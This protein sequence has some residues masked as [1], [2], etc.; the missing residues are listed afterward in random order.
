M[1]KTTFSIKKMD[2]PAE[3]QLIRMQ[4]GEFNQ[5]SFLKFDIPTRKLDVYHT[6]DHN[7]IF[8]ALTNLQLETSLAGSSPVDEAPL[9]RGVAPLPHDDGEGAERKLLIQVLVINFFFFL[10]ESLMGVIADSMGLVADSLDMLADSF[11]YGL[12]LFAVGGTAIRKKNIAK[13]SGYFQ[14]IL[15]VLGIVEVTRRFLGFGKVPSFQTMIG[16]STLALIGNAT[17]LYLLQKSNNQEAHMQASM[18]FTSNDVIINLGV[19]IAG[20]L[21]YLSHSKYPNLIIGAIVFV[22]VTRGAFRILKIAT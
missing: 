12:A 1:Q 13:A 15:A 19:I 6:G 8:E 17:S 4:L 3:E 22:I 2:C 14:L 11:V 18:I 7:S 5:I 21:V 9:N 16:I 10:L 20:T